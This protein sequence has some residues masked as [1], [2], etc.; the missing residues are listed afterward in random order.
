MLRPP[1]PAIQSFV[2]SRLSAE[3]MQGREAVPSAGTRPPRPDGRQD[4]SPVNAARS[5]RKSQQQVRGETKQFPC[6]RVDWPNLGHVRAVFALSGP[7]LQHEGLVAPPAVTAVPVLE[8]RLQSAPTALDSDF[9]LDATR[10]R[11]R[12]SAR[13]QSPISVVVVVAFPRK[14]RLFVVQWRSTVPARRRVEAEHAVQVPAPSSRTSDFIGRPHVAQIDRWN[15]VPMIH[16]PLSSPR[17][18]AGPLDL[19]WGVGPSG[20]VGIHTLSH[21]DASSPGIRARVPPAPERLHER[22]EP[23]FVSRRR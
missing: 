20:G 13:P 16:T 12:P 18:A 19:S 17:P 14:A 4:R 21:I 10:L 6:P 9:N 15:L 23:V 7:V 2:T 22:R 5:A 3:R 8:E 1:L 11:C